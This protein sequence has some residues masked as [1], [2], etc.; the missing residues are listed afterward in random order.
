MIN[1][2]YDKLGINISFDKDR[3]LI[4]ILESEEHYSTVLSDIWAQSVGGDERFLLFEQD[5][6]ISLSKNAEIIRDPF[7]LECNNK[8]I[9]S[10]LY[11]LMQEQSDDIFIEKIGSITSHIV[12]YLDG[13]AASIPY[14]LEYSL[15][16]D[17]IGLFKLFDVKIDCYPEDCRE[18]LLNYIKI[19]HR[20]CGIRFFL[21]I[22]LKSYFTKEQLE[23]LYAD[24][25]YEEICLLDI[26][27]VQ[28]SVLPCEKV[29]LLDRDC[30]IIEMD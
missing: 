21:C 13:I 16:L 2:I 19:V 24:L 14:P 4:L 10:K 3:P 18:N 8:K 30:C 20:I 12:D 17:T 27:N 22:A 6:Q 29:F 25:R 11:R 5:R 23:E 1:L 28:K 26:E 7:S 9:L 15:N